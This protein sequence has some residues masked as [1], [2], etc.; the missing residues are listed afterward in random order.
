MVPR[1][2][3]VLALAPVLMFIGAALQALR[4]AAV[5]KRPCEAGGSCV[6]GIC[7]VLWQVLPP[8]LTSLAP[9][10]PQL[11]VPGK[12]HGAAAQDAQ[13][14]R[15]NQHTLYAFLIRTWRSPRSRRAVAQNAHTSSA[16]QQYISL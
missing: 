4:Q 12:A 6:Q 15:A 16:A 11:C 3:P 7:V 13:T 9:M 10:K 14:L 5:C 2:T 8:V 1:D